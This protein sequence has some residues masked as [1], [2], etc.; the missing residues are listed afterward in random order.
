MSTKVKIGIAVA[1]ALLVVVAVF[2]L[3]KKSVATVKA[4]GAPPSANASTGSSFL[5]LGL[6]NA[7]TS[8]INTVIGG[9]G[10][11]SVPNGTPG[12]T[13]P[14]VESAKGRGHF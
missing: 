4:Q 5:Q 11:A 14:A 6:G 10:G 8:T 1:V 2:F 12:A 9:P 7:I 13:G 3:K